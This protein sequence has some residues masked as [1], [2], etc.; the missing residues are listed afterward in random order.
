MRERFTILTAKKSSSPF[1]KAHSTA[2]AHRA[3]LM[4]RLVLNSCGPD[5]AGECANEGHF[6]HRHHPDRPTES[7]D[8]HTV[9]RSPGPP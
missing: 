2:R 1:H 7:E 4:A 8:A 3:Q 5:V 6:D 9:N